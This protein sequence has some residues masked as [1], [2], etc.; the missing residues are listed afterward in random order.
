[1]PHFRVEKRKGCVAPHFSLKAQKCVLFNWLSA[2]SVVDKM[3]K[4]RFRW[5]GHVKRRY[6]AVRRCERLIAAGVR[7]GRGIPKKNRGR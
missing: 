5:F 3:R 1:M 4:A 2:A 6:A 7:R